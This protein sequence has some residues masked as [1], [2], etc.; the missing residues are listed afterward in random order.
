[1]NRNLKSHL[2][3]VG[4]NTIYGLNFVVAKGIMPD[5]LLP[6]AIVFLR[7]SGTLA[8]FWVIN[9]LLPSEKVEKK[10]LF[11]MAV[12]SIFGVVTNQIIFFEGL[13]LS[14]PIGA[15]IISTVTPIVILVFSHFILKERITGMKVLGIMLGAAGAL[16]VILSAGFGDFRSNSL[17][18]NLL[19][20]TSAA[21]WSLYLVLVKPLMEKYDSLTI[22]KWTYLSGFVI[23]FP[24]TF[25][26]IA[27]SNFAQIPFGI[28]ISVSYVVFATTAFASFLINYSLRTASP[29]L[30]G[31]YTYLQPLVASLAA[32][33]LGK[34]RLTVTDL[35]AA[36]LVTAGVYLVTRQSAMKIRPDL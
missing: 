25:P 18:G 8:L 6:R 34:D 4:A 35:I 9:F 11:K 10:D 5:F 14:A 26:Q 30:N 27:S 12:C 32:I 3:I 13:N 21:S 33:L 23:A 24:F 28:W 22:M 20:L 16:M 36:A 31:I 1:M 19:L 15:S 7:I 2:A 29:N 17:L